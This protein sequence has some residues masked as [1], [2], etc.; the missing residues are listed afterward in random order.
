MVQG[1]N[2]GLTS[3]MSNTALGMSKWLADIN[4][5]NPQ[6][7]FAVDT[8]ALSFS[9]QKSLQASVVTQ[10]HVVMDDNSQGMEEAFRTV[11]REFNMSQMVEDVRRQADKQEQTVVQIG[12]KIVTDAVVTQQRANG[13]RFVT[14]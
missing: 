6:V 8:S 9:D 13:Y 1:F 3:E 5:F 11:M 4:S 2:I 7:A 10:A 14:Q 12:N